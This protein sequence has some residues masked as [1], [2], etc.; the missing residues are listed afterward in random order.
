MTF[1][2]STEKQYEAALRLHEMYKGMRVRAEA[3]L[4]DLDDMIKDSRAR[5]DR[6]EKDHQLDQ[7]GQTA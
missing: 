1:V 7:E 2:L 5:I 6:Y 3:H 4:A